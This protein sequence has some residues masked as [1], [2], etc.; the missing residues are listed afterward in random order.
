V[1]L[2]GFGINEQCSLQLFLKERVERKLGHSFTG[3]QLD[4]DLEA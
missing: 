1:S 4:T 2:R 3:W